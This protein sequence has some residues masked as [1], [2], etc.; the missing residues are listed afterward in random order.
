VPVDGEVESGES[1]VDES[2]LTGESVPVDKSTGDKVFGGTVNQSGLLRVRA[3]GVGSETALAGIIRLVRQAQG[4]RA[5]VQ[6]VA[7]SVSAV[8][9]P[10]I[11]LLAIG[12]LVVWLSVT[13]DPSHAIVRMVAVL[14]IACPCAL[15]LA[16]PAAIMVAAGRGARQGVLFRDAAALEA[17]GRVTVV[18][19]DKTGTLTEGKPALT[20]WIPLSAD[21]DAALALAAGAESGSEHPIA[22]AVVAG[23]RE[24]AV[25]VP[26]PTSVTAVSGFGV[27]AEVDGQTVKVG[28]PGWV[29][30]EADGALSPA[31]SQRER[32][33]VDAGSTPAF[34]S[35]DGEMVGVLGVGDQV[36]DN[37][38]AVIR[39]LGGLGLRTAMLTGDDER[40]ATAIGMRLDIS[41]VVAGMLP[42]G[43]EELIRS[44][45]AAGERVAM[46][47]D[48]INDAPALARADAG[49]AMGSGTGVAVESAHVTLLNPDLMGVVRA[50]ELSR[51]TMRTI[52]QNLFWAFFY[53]LVLIPTAAGA[54]S[55]VAWVPG[56]L[57]E[58]HPAL[59]A[60]AMALSSITVVLNSLRLGRTAPSPSTFLPPTPPPR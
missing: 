34:V 44:L 43:K 5:R 51:A 32:A 3:T 22:R 1:S 60:A 55:S 18:A 19:F 13:G 46:V 37:A 30:D 7:D 10:V 45:Q 8:F 52:R 23:A 36:R 21:G 26:A 28:R 59:A 54:F 9:V 48:G 56:V 11:V 6:R 53:N 40:V 58:M 14:V 42:G 25:G 39:R 2:M 35:V 41:Q 4:S 49:I 20:H 29:V 17:L 16:T 50:V 47:G 24:R 38:S 31:L 27:V 57:R 12:T 15:G 33:I